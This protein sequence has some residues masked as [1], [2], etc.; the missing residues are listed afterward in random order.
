MEGTTTNER[1]QRFLV[2]IIH[3]HFDVSD[4]LGGNFHNVVVSREQWIQKQ[5]HHPIP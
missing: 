4:A 2:W 5:A 3:R 1:E